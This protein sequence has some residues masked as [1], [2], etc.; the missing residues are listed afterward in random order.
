LFNS[1]VEAAAP[2]Y[3]AS[4]ATSADEPGVEGQGS[5]EDRLAARHIAAT[6][7]S[8]Q[9]LVAGAPLTRQGA[10]L[11]LGAAC[12]SLLGQ[13]EMTEHRELYRLFQSQFSKVMGSVTMALR[14][15]M[16]G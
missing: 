5:R 9:A 15:R 12:G 10:M 4:F 16:D 3:T 11:A 1:L 2:L 6:S 7:L 14:E 13:C 8:I